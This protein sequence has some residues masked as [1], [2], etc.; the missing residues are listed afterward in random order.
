LAGVA[1]GL[2]GRGRTVVFLARGGR[3]LGLLALSDALKPGA[4]EA[5][6]ALGKIGL[7]VAMVTGDNKRAAEETA[8]TAG[9]SR[10]LAEVLPGRKSAEVKALQGTGEVVA[11]VGDGI[12][13]APA[14]AQ[15]DVGIALGTGTDVA[16]ET[17]DIILMRG[18]LAGVPAA[19]ALSR[20]TMRTIKQNL[21]WAF[22][23]NIIL[24]PVAAGL[25]YVFFRGGGVPV[26]LRFYLGDSGFLN[27]MLAAAA[28]ALSSVT[29]ISNSLRLRRFN[30]MKAVGGLK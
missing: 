15:S 30:P 13:D 22:A 21:F 17:G 12:N 4:V 8:R 5:V 16:V 2:W 28:M 26:G 14:L 25:L 29:V 6:A 7:K 23:Y 27:P 9:I 24:I 19:V 10:V 11:M 3:V 18:E 1:E 20:R